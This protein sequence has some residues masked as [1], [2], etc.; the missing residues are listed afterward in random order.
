MPDPELIGDPPPPLR[1][2]WRV[3]V[4]L[5]A[6]VVSWAGTA[7]W[8]VALGWQAV[9]TLPAGRAGVV[10]AISTIPQALLSLVGGVIADRCSTRA[11]MTLAQLAHAATLVVG[12]ALWGRVDAWWLLLGLGLV[13]GCIT[14]LS[15]PASATLGRQLV[16]SKDLTTVSSWNQVG[17]RVARM[18]GA[19]IGAGIVAARGRRS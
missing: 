2:D 19:P 6:L 17:A 12:A 16:A 13:F 5:A 18:A 4:W 9:Q 8:T 1:R 3:I 14:G 7:A 10:V 11:V 15:A